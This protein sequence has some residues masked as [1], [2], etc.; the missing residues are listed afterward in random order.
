M[1]TADR[2]T[3]LDALLRLAHTAACKEAP[4]IHMIC[5]HCRVFPPSSSCTWMVTGLNP[6]ITT[7]TDQSRISFSGHLARHRYARDT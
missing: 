6:Q 3:D 7:G 5:L 1:H 2:H 4:V